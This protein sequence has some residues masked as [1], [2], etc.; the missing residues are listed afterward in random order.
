M[1]ILREYVWDAIRKN[2]R[3]SIAIMVA[4]FLMT[5]MMTA[6]CGFVYTQWTDSIVLTKLE[7]GD[8]HGELFDVTYGR[9]LEKI[10]TYASVS[11][12]MVKGNW[13]AARLPEEGRRTYIISRNASREYWESMPEKDIVTKGRIPAAANEIVLSK[14]YFADYPDVKIGDTLTLPVGQRVYNGNVCKEVE[15]YRDGETF[16]QTDTKSY[17]IVGEMDATTSSVVPAYTGMGYLDT[18]TVKPE[19][20]ITVYLRFDPM[21]STYKE[22]PALA[23]SVGYEKD[24]YGEYNLRY[25]A[26]LLSKYAILSPEQKDALDKLNAFAVPLMFLV[27]AGLLVSVFVLVIYNAFALSAGE[28][29]SQLGILSGI[30]A[31]PRQ[32]RSAVTMEAFVLSIIPLPLGI[33]AG[34]GTDVLLV[35]LINASNDIGRAAPDIV[36]SFGLPALLPSAVLSLLTAWLSAGIPARRAARLLPVE[37][38]KQGDDFNKK[39]LRK[40]RIVSK[41]GIVGE[42]AAN[43]LTARKKSYRTATISLCLSFL[44]LTGFLYTM[45][46]QEASRGVYGNVEDTDSHVNM[47]LSD[48]RAPDMEAIR[49]VKHIP[50]ITKSVIY[51]KLQCATWI[52]KED[53][54]EE[55]EKHLGGFGKI[56]DE[57]KYTTIERGGKYRIFSL[58]VGLEG[59]SFRQYCEEQGIDPE[60]Y[61]EDP[62][63]AIIYNYTEDPEASTKK[64]SVYRE[65][66]KLEKGQKITFTEK[67]YDEDTGEFTFE[68]EAADIVKEMPMDRIITNYFTI[69]AVMPME[70]VLKITPS[71]SEKRRLSTYNTTGNFLTDDT[72]G[73]SYARIKKVTAR[74]EDTLSRYYG[75][76]DYMCSDITQKAEM[77]KE[78][79]D[80]MGQIVTFLT[81]LLALIGLSNVWASIYGNLRQ[82]AR[83]FAMLKSAGLSPKQLKRMLLL[84][85]MTLGLKPLLL[86][87]PFQVAIL[88]VFLSVNE[89]TLAE[90]LPYAPFT[91]VLGYTF[92]VV[93]AITGA[94][95]IGGRRIQQENI[96][97]AIRDET[98]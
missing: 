82:R 36:L 7:T 8:W 25:N 27:L 62:S 33:L 24:E 42:L 37:A 35:G 18:K 79:E 15:P 23:A 56:V 76:G 2:K 14:Q 93:L 12:V 91:A 88:G 71:V 10:E 86:S 34:W 6:F 65:M 11:S 68:I 30:G 26:E 40:S 98:V 85:G 32:I 43:A 54:S 78:A 59:D 69:G 16:R 80:A 96:I 45:T 95:I 44:L 39:K 89:V 70:H 64:K 61:F 53:T 3:A 94:Y 52:A 50:G 41:F 19:D 67:A 60:P 29:M 77:M 17:K 49:K 58:L 81:G 31:S 13:E 22:L 1:K 48:G 4:L 20:E 92:L 74:M 97:T 72:D 38:I 5:T 83:E 75:S 55:I 21:R 63:K 84:E 46:I 47:L 87:I 73:I 66:L 9:D 51:N 90:Y 28:K 57:G